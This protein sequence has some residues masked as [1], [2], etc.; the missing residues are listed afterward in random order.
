[1]PPELFCGFERTPTNRPVRYPVACSP[2][3]W[4]TGAVFQLLQIMV[5]LVPDVPNNCL[6]HCAAYSA[7]IGQLFVAEKFQNRS[8]PYWTLSLSEIPMR[9]PPVGCMRKRG[10]LR[11]VIEA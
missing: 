9:P 3:A 2:Q 4:A 6:P 10:N 5:N 11:V 8:I 7:R 1:V